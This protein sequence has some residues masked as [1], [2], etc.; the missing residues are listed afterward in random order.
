[1]CAVPSSCEASHILVKGSGSKERCMELKEEVLDRV[2]IPMGACTPVS[3]C[4]HLRVLLCKG[5]FNARASSCERHACA[6]PA[7]AGTHMRVPRHWH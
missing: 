5:V 6:Q 3:L 7:D 1:M 4:A 2:S